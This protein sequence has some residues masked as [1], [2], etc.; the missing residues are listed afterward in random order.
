[1]PAHLF[2]CL[3]L[4]SCLSATASLACAETWPAADWAS[5]P[6]APSPAIEALEAYAFPARDDA[7]RKGIRTDALLVIRDG[8]I[9]Y[10]RYAGPTKAETPHLTWSVSK[11]LM[12]ATLG[13]AYGNGRFKLDDP[14]AKFYPPFAG[15]PEVKLGHLLNWASGLA[16]EEGYEYAPLKST[17]V[18]MLYTRGRADMAAYAASIDQEVA[19]GTR[20]RYSSGDS[21]LL[22]AALKGA[23]GEPAYK[24]YPWTALFEPLGITSA[25]WET[26]ASGTFVASSYAYMTARDLARVGLLMQRDGRW[27]KRQLLPKAWIAFNRTPFANYQPSAETAGE[28][29]PGGQWWLNAAVAG[30]AKPWPD[31]PE[32]GFAALGHW[33]QA[34]YVVPS[35]KLVIVRYG[36]DRD[37]SYQHNQLLKLAKAAFAAQVNP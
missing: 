6:S 25:V 17:V 3:C 37:K 11:S 27:G 26:D 18:A 20:F 19:P 22:S 31:V 30:A 35:E 15:H 5:A 2:R 7:T 21:N 16:W 34:L 14:V 4:A 10:E 24:T 23:V 13:T 12:A 29:V 33:G 36:D 28:A 8:A 9:V 32:D 1:M